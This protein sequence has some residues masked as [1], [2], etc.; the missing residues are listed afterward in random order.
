MER[1]S[2]TRSEGSSAAPGCI[3]VLASRR[4]FTG[5]PPSALCPHPAAAYDHGRAQ[6]TRRSR[7]TPPFSSPLAWQCLLALCFLPCSRLLAVVRS[8]R[9]HRS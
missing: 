8:L 1:G 9:D 7:R 2:S 5:C 3:P 4:H 6:S